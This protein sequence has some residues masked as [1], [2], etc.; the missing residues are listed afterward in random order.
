MSVQEGA[1]VLMADGTT[2]PIQNCKRGQ[3][4][5]TVVAG[6]LVPGWINF[7]S[8]YFENETITLIA[9]PCSVT[10]EPTAL[11][12]YG[13]EVTR[14]KLAAMLKPGDEIKIVDDGIVSIEAISC[15][16][17]NEGS[18]RIYDVNIESGGNVVANGVVV[19]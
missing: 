5:F 7:S 14:Y 17:T 2:Q 18:S 11:V 13:T 8:S 15:I 16:T 9:G 6:R 1:A 12:G 10:V 4:V 19:R 3:R